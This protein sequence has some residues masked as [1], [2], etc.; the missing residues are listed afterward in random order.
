MFWK[1]LRDFTRTLSFRL[2]AWHAVVFLASAAVSFTLIYF[3]LGAAIERKDRDVIEARLREYVAVY[4]SGGVAAL[5]D[6]T[7]RVNEARKERMFFVRVTNAIGAV[8]LQVMPQDWFD[9]DL[10]K[11]DEEAKAEADDWTRVPR[12]RETDL[13]LATRILDDRTVF[14][15]GRSSDSRGSLLEKFR[16]VFAIIIPPVLL[17]GFI[18]GALLTRRMTKPIRALV[19]AASSIINTGRMDVRVP[20]RRAE[21]ELQELVLLFNRMLEHN[22]K[23]FHALRDSLD[24]VAHDLRTPLSRLRVSLEESLRSGDQGSQNG[25]IDAL[26]ETDR[27]QTII[28]TLMDVAQAE[29]GLMPLNVQPTSIDSL[30]ADIVGLY[31]HIAQ[32][33]QIEIATKIADQITVPLDAA[34]MR[35]A[36][37]NLLD[38]AIKYTPS[39]GRVE[40]AARTGSG[41]MEIVFRDTGAGIA[42]KDLPRIWERLYRTDQSRSALGLGL[43]LSLVKAIVEAHDGSVV[44]SSIEREG[45]K[46][47]II[48]PLRPIARGAA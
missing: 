25:I 13:T 2:N 15:V 18:G 8:Q 12:N 41:Q 45:S 35:Q 14:Q 28:H 36:F 22:E 32:E 38:N 47:T 39:G 4:Q 43:G 48:L 30:V 11:V 7:T 40:I 44:V 27:V 5:R 9:R 1:A 46:F 42:E 20:E 26:E 37:A 23:L 3:L 16:E 19:E 34:R 21:D 17:I 33:K 24:N 6:W 10:Q 31:E 29:S